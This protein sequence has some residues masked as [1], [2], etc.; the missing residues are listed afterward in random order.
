MAMS[1]GSPIPSLDGTELEVLMD[2][3]YQNVERAAAG[4]LNPKLS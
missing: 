1:E 3:R 4:D 2:I